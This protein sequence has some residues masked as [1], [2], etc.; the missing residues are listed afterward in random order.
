MIC[1]EVAVAVPLNSTLTY[2]YDPDDILEGTLT[3]E[4]LIGRRVIVPLSGRLVTGYVLGEKDEEDHTYRLKKIKSIVD[5]QNLFHKDGIELF[6]W[7]ANYYQYPIGEVISVA[8]PAGL[9]QSSRRAI[10]L[11][12]TAD[13][14]LLN[15]QSAIHNP[16]TW[17]S[18]LFEKKK[19]TP[20]KSSKILTSKK[21]KAILKSLFKA[22]ILDIKNELTRGHT[23]EKTEI[24]FHSDIH[25]PYAIVADE[26][27]TRES[28]R[29]LQ[30]KLEKIQGCEL[31]FSET[32]AFYHYLIL[33]EQLQPVPQK[34]ILRRYKSAITALQRLCQKGL[35]KKSRQRIYRNPF[36]EALE[37]TTR[38]H[39]LSAEQHQAIQSINESLKLDEFS[40][41]LLHGVTGSG[42]TEVYLRAA[43]YCLKR[44]K[45]ILV[46]VPEIALATQLESHF[47]SRFKGLVALLHSGLSK[48]ERFDQ[49]SLAADGKAKIVIGARSAI[50]A[51][52][53]NIGLI[54]VDEEHDS[55]YKQDD[56]L[57]YNARDLAVLRAQ[58]RNC[59][60]ILGSATP[61]ITSYHHAQRGKYRLLNMN[62]RVGDSSLPDVTI[63]DLRQ[64]SIQDTKAFHESFIE[65]LQTN[66]DKKEQ[67]L[68]LLNRRGFSAAYLCQ[69]CGTA[70]QC[71]HC[72]VTLTYHRYI[73]RLIC[74]YCGFSL[75]SSILCANCHSDKLVPFGFGTER[76]TA[77]LA[78]VFPEAVITR[79][80][81]DTAADRKK[82]LK[83]FQAMRSG[84]IDILIGTQMIA[85]GHHFPNVTFVG[86]VWADGGLNMPDFRA[87]ERTYQLLAQVT[88]RAGRGDKKGRVIIQT[89][90]PNHYAI[91]LAK[92]HQYHDFYA[93]ELKIRNNPLFPP[94]VRLACFR[95][96]GDSEYN[97]KKTSENLARMCSKISGE[98]KSDLEILGPASSPLEK[99]KDNY[100]WQLL[101]KSAHSTILQKT[102]S[103]ILQNKK[104]LCVG[105]VHLS[106][107]MDPENMM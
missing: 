93:K 2:L 38:P 95:V 30:K 86:V 46:L 85:K 61:S 52:L 106:F 17:L 12:A 50:F 63:L 103:Y 66:L 57:R 73:E 54:I 71:N 81:S 31:L 18:E 88:G 16:P 105:R 100:R 59:C 3:V 83:I 40:T 48:G 79:L 107:D 74:H 27:I 92:N 51:P 35:I 29:D 65:E 75:Y 24:C 97:V 36:G 90:R 7:V 82:F 49:W 62:N 80:D 28:L 84:E 55:G 23:H 104:D 41:Y 87:A 13:H 33:A 37:P 64:S 4:Q 10:Y 39:N 102:G 21:D 47:V 91:E 68:V 77:E 56:S 60:V 5:S 22:G 26:N 67:S 72:K 9:K 89:M 44:D 96:Y 6:R 78:T 45:D 19:L 8:L 101:L 25:L 53:A 69:E 42:K 20:A 32:K 43:E 15:H 58:Q 1:L 99:I 11:N 34:E 70:V 94:Y 14:N 76:I 98:E